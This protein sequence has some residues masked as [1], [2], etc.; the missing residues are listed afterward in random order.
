M[1]VLV[2]ALSAIIMIVTRLLAQYCH[3]V[4]SPPSKQLQGED[5]KAMLAFFQKVAE[6]SRFQA[7]LPRLIALGVEENQVEEKRSK[8]QRD[9]SATLIDADYYYSYFQGGYC[10]RP[11]LHVLLPHLP[12]AFYRVAEAGTF[13]GDDPRWSDGGISVHFQL[14]QVQQAET[15]S[16]SANE[17]SSTTGLIAD[18]PL[19]P[20]TLR[21]L[22]CHKPSQ[23]GI[24]LGLAPY[25]WHEAKAAHELLHLLRHLTRQKSLTSNR[26]IFWEEILVWRF[27]RQY[28]N[29]Y[30]VS[31][32]ALLAA[33]IISVFMA[34][35][36]LLDLHIPQWVWDDLAKPLVRK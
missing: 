34:L 30:V 5:R 4:R 13:C 32:L 9:L 31:R 28:D 18:M 15:E 36:L 14:V 17:R 26:S 35:A 19:D 2:L 21:R 1:W 29:R 25:G 3:W 22:S 10:G 24:G 11:G 33:L 20:K 16:Q 27:T 6:D 12:E 8:L 7:L 23:L